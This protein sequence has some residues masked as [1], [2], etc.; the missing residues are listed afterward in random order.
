[1]L[2]RKW[3]VCVR[4]RANDVVFL[5]VFDFGNKSDF[6]CCLMTASKKE[7]GEGLR[8]GVELKWEEGSADGDERT[9]KIGRRV[10]LTQEI[11]NSTLFRG[12]RGEGCF[13]IDAN[14]N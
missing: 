9:S 4:N 5:I 14:E 1:M 12:V 10:H 7:I 13:L 11:F 8:W 6:E 2:E 3:P